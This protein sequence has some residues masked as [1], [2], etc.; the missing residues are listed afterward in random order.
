MFNWIKILI[1]LAKLLP[2]IIPLIKQIIEAINGQDV[3]P[4]IRKEQLST[5]KRRFQHARMFRTDQANDLLFSTM[6]G[7]LKRRPK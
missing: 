4:A 5:L 1:E 7:H 3:A 6:A 2:V